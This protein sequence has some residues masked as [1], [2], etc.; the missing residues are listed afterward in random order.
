MAF[1]SDDDKL[2]KDNEQEGQAGAG[3]LG[4]VDSSAPGGAIVGGGSGG[5]GGGASSNPGW[6]N[7]QN[8]LS[9]NQGDTGSSQKLQTAADTTFGNE[10]TNLQ[11][12]ATEAKTQAKTQ[13][14]NSIGKDQA[15]KLLEGAA[16]NYSWGGQ[17]NDAYKQSTD[18]LKGAMNAQWQAPSGFAYGMGKETQEMGEGLGKE[19]G[20]SQI[21]RNLYS[22]SA[23]KPLSRGQYDL[24]AQLDSSSE[25]LAKARQDAQAKYSGLKD[26]VNQTVTS[27]DQDLKNQMSV[28]NKNRDEVNQSLGKW[29]GDYRDQADKGLVDAR[30]AYDASFVN[31][32][33]GVNSPWQGWA[34]YGENITPQQAKELAAVREAHRGD[35]AEG[36]P[37]DQE[38]GQTQS[39][40]DK[41]YADQDAKYSHVAEPERKK[42]NT[43][44]QILGL[45]QPAYGEQTNIVRK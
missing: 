19:D 28:F 25:A 36:S 39:A 11:N 2:L 13:V 15:S 38:F 23:G 21:M 29:A 34:D 18:Q 9:A 26:N 27:T 35:F 37:L 17:Q 6:T 30:N 16:Q 42:W 44:A 8:Y 14:D 40:L 10:Q 45:G 7:I 22:Q 5:M 33:L 24:Q 3:G 1:I 41:W 43:L 31:D 32:H 12:K 4:L 20:F